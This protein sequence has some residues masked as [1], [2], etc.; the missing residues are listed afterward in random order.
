MAQPTSLVQLADSP[1]M[2]LLDTK[3][4]RIVKT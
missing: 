3:P 1:G 4:D 2:A